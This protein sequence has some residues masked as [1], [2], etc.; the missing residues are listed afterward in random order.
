MFFD[1]YY[2][3]RDKSITQKKEKDRDLSNPKET[4][5]VFVW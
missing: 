4:N 5:A 2:Y 1:L 3:E